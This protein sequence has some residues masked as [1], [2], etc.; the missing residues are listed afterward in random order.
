MRSYWAPGGP[1]TSRC[2]ETGP[3][4]LWF[5]CLYCLNTERQVWGFAMPSRL[6]SYWQATPAIKD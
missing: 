5:S 6:C 1:S 4:V 2:G 3:A